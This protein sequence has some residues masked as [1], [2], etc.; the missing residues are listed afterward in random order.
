MKLKMEIK[1][2]KKEFNEGNDVER[3]TLGDLFEKSIL[4]DT[5]IDSTENK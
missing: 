2:N 3:K 1:R 5:N 4:N